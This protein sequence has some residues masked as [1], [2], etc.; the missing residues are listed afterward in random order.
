MVGFGLKL[1]CFRKYIILAV[2]ESRHNSLGVRLTLYQHGG[3]CR[4]S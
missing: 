2:L 4:F 3:G 1:N